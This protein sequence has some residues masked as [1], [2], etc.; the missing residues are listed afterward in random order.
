MQYFATKLR[1]AQRFGKKFTGLVRGWGSKFHQHVDRL[2]D[3]LIRSQYSKHTTQAGNVLHKSG[4]IVGKLESAAE[5]LDMNKPSMAVKSM[6]F[7]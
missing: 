6:G 2:G 7:N 1:N 5:N 4:R 3:A